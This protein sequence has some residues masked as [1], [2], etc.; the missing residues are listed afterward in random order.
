MSDLLGKASKSTFKYVLRAKGS[1]GERQKT[2]CEQNENINKEIEIIKRNQKEILELK[3]R[4]RKMKSTMKGVKSRYE[5]AMEAVNLKIG[6]LKWSS[7]EQKE[8]KVNTV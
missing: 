1:Y 6:Q 7:E 5:I 4:I 8:E 3:N 2:I